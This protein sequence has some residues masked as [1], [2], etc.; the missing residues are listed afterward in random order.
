MMVKYIAD[1][2]LGR[3][4]RWLRLLGVDVESF[5]RDDFAAFLERARITSR[6][7]ITTRKVTISIPAVFIRPDRIEG[8]VES[9]FSSESL[10]LKRDKFFTRCSA[11]NRELE[12]ISRDVAAAR[13]VPEY[14]L[15]STNKFLSCLDCNRVYWPGSHKDRFLEK[16]KAL[17]IPGSK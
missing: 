6:K 14:V 8:Q 5:G 7:V 1:A 2:N 9:F 10:E 12:E 15:L 13:G 3:L 11:C 4:A 17:K 16:M